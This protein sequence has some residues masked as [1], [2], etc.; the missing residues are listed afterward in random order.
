MEHDILSPTFSGTGGPVTICDW[1]Y[2]GSRV[3]VLPS[4]KI[5]EGAV[6]ASCA[7]VTKDV[8]PWTVVGGVPAKPISQRP[9]VNYTLNTKSRMYF[10]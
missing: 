7:V 4:V 1:V 10:Q 8:E 2:I 6:V 9:H 3:T 5:G